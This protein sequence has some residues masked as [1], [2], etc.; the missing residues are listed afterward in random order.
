VVAFEARL[1]FTNAALASVAPDKL[2]G[3][4]E[5][6][7][8]LVP[9]N[10]RVLRAACSACA[11]WLHA[12]VRPVPVAVRIATG[13]VTD[14]SFPGEVR[15]T[16]DRSGIDASLLELD[17]TEEVLLYDTGR[18]AR[19]LAALKS[20]GVAL[21]VEEFGAGKASFADLQRFP[22]DALKLHSVRIAGIELD[23]DKQRYAEGVIALGRALGLRIVA[24][25][26]ASQGDAEHLRASGCEQLHGTIGPH[27][28]SAA[29]C[30][31]LLR[32]PR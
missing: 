9:M 4:A 5:A 25:G 29:E 30:E 23:L 10:Q 8:L 20:L 17:V 21:A 7:G 11:A 1:R 26:V 16:L 24:T 12:G 15:E 31:A 6:G 22:L 27:G 3:A 28:L 18:S 19:T 13:Q 32:A 2:Q 14:Q